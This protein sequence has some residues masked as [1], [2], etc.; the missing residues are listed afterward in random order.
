MELGAGMGAV[1]TSMLQDYEQ[2]RPLELAAIGDAV[3]RAGFPPG[4]VRWSTSKS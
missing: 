2:G 1:R 4:G 3:R